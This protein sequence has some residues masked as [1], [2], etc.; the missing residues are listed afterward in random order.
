MGTN[1]DLIAEE[2]KASKMVP[3]RVHCES[4]TFFKMAGEL[5]G[6][7][8]LDLACGEGFYT[9]QLRLRGATKAVGVDISAGMIKLAEDSE[10]RNPLGIEYHVADAFALQLGA[11]FDVVTASYF[12]NYA[13]NRDELKN[14]AKTIFDHLKPGGRFITINSNPDYQCSAHAMRPFGFTRE[15]DSYDEGAEI[16]YRFYGADGSSIDVMNYHIDSEVHE[17]CLREAGF[18]EITW[19]PVEVSPEGLDGFGGEYWQS[20]IDC[21]P[22]IG[23]MCRKPE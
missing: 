18:D 7:S 16:T 22:V 19:Q 11:T 8:I 2:Y 14:A 9:R 5:S 15:N 3:W 13:R 4:Y 10:Q 21:R 23:L 1:Y 6:L 17:Q 20:L 12:L